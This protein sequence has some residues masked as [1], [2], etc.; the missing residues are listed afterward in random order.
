MTPLQV[1]ENMAR[2]QQRDAS[3]SNKFFFKKAVC[4]SGQSTP[5]S[6]ASSVYGSTTL[7]GGAPRGKK[8]KNCFSSPPL[9]ENGDTHHGPVE[10]E[11]EE[12]TMNEIMN[13]KARF[14]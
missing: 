5:S 10:D 11:Y 14:S 2:A 1:D 8:M 3:A 4:P 12:M 7:G 9:T 13:G 6:A